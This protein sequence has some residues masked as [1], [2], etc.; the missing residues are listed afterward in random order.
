MNKPKDLDPLAEKILDRLSTR[1][2]AGE[3]VL[4]GYFA[5]K[6]YLD[7]RPTHDIDAWWRTG[8]AYATERAIEQVMRAIAD[9]E[10]LGFEKR[11]F[12]DTISFEFLREGQRI[13]SFQIALRSVEL[14]EAIASPWPPILIETLADNVGAKMNA[15]VDRGAPRDFSD[16]KHLADAHLVDASRCW[17]LWRKKNPCED[18]RAA[19]DKVRLHLSGIQ[20]RRPLES[21]KE[22]AKRLEAQATREWFMS[23]FL[24]P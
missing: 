5:L 22:I 1:E 13:F 20:A 17:E 10:Q 2:E 18:E 7:Y 16:I 3:I 8:V 11:R 9:E 12:G 24:K 4:G 21:I 23:E 6:H 15:L 19:K 14:E